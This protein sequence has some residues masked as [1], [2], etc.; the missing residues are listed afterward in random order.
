MFMNP[1]MYQ[2]GA[3]NQHQIRQM[4]WNQMVDDQADH[5]SDTEDVMTQ[6]YEQYISQGF[7]KCSCSVC[8]DMMYPVLIR[9]DADSKD[10]VEEHGKYSEL[11][12]YSNMENMPLPFNM[13]P[14][15]QNEQ[16]QQ[17][18]EPDQQQ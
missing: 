3:M 5:K 9:H 13:N 2:P 1:L 7:R 17:Q 11:L 10:F 16:P 15:P 14:A 8:V 18:E 6:F 12:G 4:Q